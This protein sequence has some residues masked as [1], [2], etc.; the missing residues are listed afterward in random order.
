M[1]GGTDVGLSD[2]SV[3]LLV[4]VAVC[5]CQVNTVCV[6]LGLG[7][8]VGASVSLAIGCTDLLPCP[9]VMCMCQWE[10]W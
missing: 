1:R 10:C 4:A 5:V 8:L 7:G 9:L 2:M 3:W 6:F